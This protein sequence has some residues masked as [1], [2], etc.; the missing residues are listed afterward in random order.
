M[1]Y[2]KAVMS[3]TS[4]LVKISTKV[5]NSLTSDERYSRIYQN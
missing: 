2:W 1:D 3:F 5:D 4:V